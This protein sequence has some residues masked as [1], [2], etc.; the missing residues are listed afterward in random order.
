[1]SPFC[2]VLW[3]RT[4]L[5][6]NYTYCTAELSSKNNVSV[7]LVRSF[8]QHHF[9]VHGLIFRSQN[10][11]SKRLP[12]HVKATDQSQNTLP[13]YSSVLQI[14]QILIQCTSIHCLGLSTFMSTLLWTGM[15]AHTHTRAHART[16]ARTHTDTHLCFHKKF[17]VFMFPLFSV[18]SQ[19]SSRSGFVI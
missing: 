9:L 10:R 4:H 18:T 16:H 5:I 13:Y 2:L 8:T 15:Y 17:K 6:F 11:R 19:R 3:F 12:S 7:F 14:F 1:M